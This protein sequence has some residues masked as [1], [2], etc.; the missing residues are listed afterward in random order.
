MSIDPRLPVIVGGGQI[1]HRAEGLDDALDPVEL[2]VEAIRRAATDAGLTSVPRPDS[3]RVVDLLSWRYRD[4]ARFVAAALGLTPRETALSTSGGNSPQTLV[5]TT[6]GEIQ[7]GELDVAVLTGA[8]A[9]RTR[10]RSRKLGQPL[11]WPEVAETVRPDRVLGTP[12]E[13]THPAERERGI[14]M[15]VQVYP[16]FESALRAAAGR[17][18]EEHLVAV[19]ELWAG[20]SAVAATNPH[21]WVR[22]PRTAEQLRTPSP[23]N[24]MIG[25]PYTKAM[26]SNNDV[27]QGAAVIMCSVE[28][29]RRL[30]VAEDRWVF[31]HAGSDAHEHP[32]VSNR[33]SFA[34]TPAIELA[35]RRALELAGVGINDIGLIDLY[36]CFPAAVQLGAASLGLGLDR[37]LTR[38]GGLS[39]AGGPWNDYVMH[40]IA[41]MVTD[42]RARP[43]ELGLV[44]ANGGFAT[45]HSFGVYSTRP[46]TEGFRW[47]SPQ[48]ELDAGPRREVLSDASGAT[49]TIEAYTV[50]HDRAGTPE[51][52]IAACLTA[53][54]HRVWG[55]SQAP[56]VASAMTDGEWVGRPAEVGP[57]GDLRV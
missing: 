41:T 40:A 50:M 34:H 32:F 42:L 46:P 7:R 37:Q 57:G 45:K 15:P 39:F 47:E 31:V 10:M 52:A 25:L 38:T 12:L 49:L 14:V 28:A 11:P 30:G 55:T 9:W 8:E 43:D 16:M 35:G 17:G 51:Q 26:N 44:W 21:A 23:D 48:A 13:M 27:D 56:E 3:I 1:S 54:G 18:V 19:S 53:D 24:R 33:W 4:P 2:M 22:T 6:A 20:F 29:A 36:S 5:N